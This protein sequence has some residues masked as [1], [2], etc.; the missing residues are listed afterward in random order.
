MSK[1]SKLKKWNEA[2]KDADFTAAKAAT[3]LTNNA[4]LL[5]SK[6]NALDLACGRAGN[7]SFLAKMKENDFQIDAIDF[8]SIVIESLKD[9]AVK[10]GLSITPILR[11]IEAD[12]L[13]NKKYDVIVVSYFLNRSLFPKIIDALKPKGLL[14]YQTWS[15]EKIDDSG[16]SN[17]NFRLSSS[18][19]LTLC[20]EM[21]ILLYR[22]EGNTG[23]ISAGSRNEAMIIAQKNQSARN[24]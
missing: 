23:N 22:E 24:G 6:G 5:P 11:D 12:G 4:H 7:A 16:P 8:S 3:I 10:N 19:L 9:Y 14:F 17:P 1:L 18:E 15:Q 20:S 21:K 13:S 2:Y